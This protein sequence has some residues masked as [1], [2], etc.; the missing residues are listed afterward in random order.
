MLP[1]EN[2]SRPRSIVART[3]VRR[4]ER[5]VRRG[6]A[7]RVAR[8]TATSSRTSTGSPTSSTRWRGGRR[9][10]T[11][12]C[13][14]PSTDRT[15]PCSDRHPNLRRTRGPVVLSSRPRPAEAVDADLLAVPIGRGPR[16]SVRAPTPSTAR[17]TAARRLH[18]GGRLR[19]QARAGAVG[20]DLRR[21]DRGRGVLVGVGRTRHAD[22]RRPAPRR[23]PR[24]PSAPP[25]WRRSPRRSSTSPPGRGSTAPRPRPGGGRGLRARLVPVPQVQGRREGER[26]SRTSCSR[27]GAAPALQSCGRPGVRRSPAPSAWARDMVNEPSGAKSPAAFAD[28][29]PEAAARASRS[30]SRCSRARSSRPQALGGV[31]GVGQGSANPPRFVKATYSPARRA[32]QRSRSSARASCS[33][34]AACR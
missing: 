19:R 22:G 18:G 3:V 28:A 23:A 34:P 4:A 1:G 17:S 16:A 29:G 2:R 11:D 8:R 5:I 7:R 13:A 26:C 25:R 15:R 6:G 32:G 9:A 21:L 33:T 12:R 20:A 14:R 24:S 31:L 27:G 30:R 10:R